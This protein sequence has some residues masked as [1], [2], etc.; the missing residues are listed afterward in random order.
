MNNDLDV[1][2]FVSFVQTLRTMSYRRKCVEL[3]IRSSKIQPKTMAKAIE[4][5]MEHYSNLTTDSSKSGSSDSHNFLI[6][7]QLLDRIFKFYLLLKRLYPKEL[8]EK[9][10]EC[11]ES[12]K[13]T[14][15]EVEDL[16][17][18][19]LQSHKKEMELPKFPSMRVFVE[20]FDLNSFLSTPLTAAQVIGGIVNFSPKNNEGKLSVISAIFSPFIFGE[21]DA[22]EIVEEVIPLSGLEIVSF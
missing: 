22:I 11:V 4:K 10:E 16:H 19:L 13:L 9:S 17:L 15:F 20:Q 18:N 1:E 8:I 14:E 3:A 7:L 2:K 6:F 5:L 12:L 21:I